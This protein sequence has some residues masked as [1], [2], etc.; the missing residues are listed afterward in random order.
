MKYYLVEFKNIKTTEQLNEKIEEEIEKMKRVGYTFKMA[1]TIQVGDPDI[2][3]FTFE[4]REEILELK[5]EKNGNTSSKNTKK[6]SSTKRS[7]K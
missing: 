5:E 7:A 6:R 2:V 1:Q 3:A 4:P